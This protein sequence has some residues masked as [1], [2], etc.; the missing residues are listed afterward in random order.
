[1]PLFKLD[2]TITVKAPFLFAAEA[3]PR[4]GLDAASIRNADGVL[5]LP[6]SQVKGVARHFYQAGDR[7]ALFGKSSAK[8]S[9]DPQRGRLVFDDLICETPEPEAVAQMTRIRIDEGTGAVETGHMLVIDSPFLP[10]TNVTF[11]GTAYLDAEEGRQQDITQAVERSLKAAHAIGA[12]KS[13]GF[14]R[15][16]KASVKFAEPVQA[17]LD[18][19]EW[20]LTCTPDR[21]FLVNA[22][23][24]S[25]NVIE[26]SEAIPGAAL[27]AALAAGFKR[28]GEKD[29]D[30]LIDSIRISHAFPVNTGPRPKTPPLSL[31]K[32]EPDGR[33]EF[34]DIFTDDVSDLKDP[35]FFYQADF[36]DGDWEEIP[37]DFR[38]DADL[39]HEYR[40]HTSI[41]EGTFTAE[42]GALYALK[43]I[44][45]G[46]HKWVA[47][48]SLPGDCK[49]D[50]RDRLK[51][52][53]GQGLY[54]VGRT[55]AM[56]AVT[57]EEAETVDLPEGECLA[58]TLQTPACLHTA[59]DVQAFK[60]SK[61][62][63]Q[64]LWDV[65][66]KYWETL[67]CTL[68]DFR[69]A[70]HWAGGALASRYPLPVQGYHPW[71]LTS[72]GSTF[73]IEPGEGHYLKEAL[74][75]GLPPAIKEDWRTM[76]FGRRVGYGEIYIRPA[77]QGGA[78]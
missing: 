57:A 3:N 63:G 27:K 21:P 40:V 43:C 35:L 15:I 61:N 60:K 52:V 5:I 8:G 42:E 33:P 26:G 41:T 73:L 25:E 50:D 64:W 20:Q 54:P 47:H 11:K 65:Y 59:D 55:S 16:Q 32:A 39:R 53:L 4:Y 18:G 17:P 29:Y 12:M 7:D 34:R 70:Q 68:K 56:L 14:G 24:P 31:V 13:V 75:R 28:A 48:L 38:S 30:A 66:A 72:A 67:G 1:M 19:T 36:K 71:L 77:K 10:E 44:V 9:W 6:G 58:V 37:E 51:K 22:T 23:R 49:P 2:V 45:P 69:A 78:A 74:V 76:P 46:S 62:P